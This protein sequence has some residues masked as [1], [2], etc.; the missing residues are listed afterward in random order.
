MSDNSLRAVTRAFA[1]KSIGKMSNRVIGAND[2]INVG[3]FGGAG[4]CNSE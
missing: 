4:S 2:R 3:L 1:A